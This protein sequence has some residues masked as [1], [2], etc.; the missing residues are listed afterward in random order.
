M[1]SGQRILAIQQS[2]EPI[3][4]KFYNRE[5]SYFSKG[6]IP[7]HFF[8]IW[9]VFDILRCPDTLDER[10]HSLP[11]GDRLSGRLGRELQIQL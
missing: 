8:F 9:D 10:D 3:L 11:A 7:G 6:H 4:L 2:G 1:L 5:Y